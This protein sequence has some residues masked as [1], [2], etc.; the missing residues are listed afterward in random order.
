MISIRVLTAVWFALATTA[1]GGNILVVPG[2]YQTIYYAIL[3]AQDGDT[4]IVEPGIRAHPFDYGGK[5]ITISSIDPNDPAIVASTILKSD[6]TQPVVRFAGT[7]TAE[8][9][10]TGFTITGGAATGQAQDGWGGGISC[11]GASPT[12]ENCIVTGNMAL[13]GGGIADCHGSIRNC[14][15]S[16]NEIIPPLPGGGGGLYR[17]NGEIV[18]CL[19]S[20]NKVPYGSGGGLAGC[21]GRIENCLVVGNVAS[22]GGGFAGG[23]GL[24][25][26]CTIVGNYA[27]TGPAM[28]ACDGIITNSIVWYHGDGAPLPIVDSSQPTFSCIQYATSGLGVTGNDPRF[29]DPGSWANGQIGSSWVL[30][31]NRLRAGSPCIDTGDNLAVS[32]LTDIAGKNRLSRCFVDIGAYEFPWPVSPLPGNT[33]PASGGI[34]A[35]QPIDADDGQPTGWQ[36]VEMTLDQ[37]PAVVPVSDDFGIVEIGSDGL[38]P[39]IMAV[40]AVDALTFLVMLDEP[41]AIGA[42]TIITHI[43]SGARVQLGYLPADVFGNGVSTTA[44]VITLIELIECGDALPD[45][46]TDTN[47]SGSTNAE[48]IETL[49]DLLNGVDGANSY[50]NVSLPPLP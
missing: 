3:D 49:I 45:Y 21:N 18:N 23:D 28:L 48:D 14:I 1:F 34:D 5:L 46:S 25:S 19:I 20:N 13:S 31:D 7:E 35:R 11:H 8:A 6:G 4:I 36:S 30:G 15:I 44:D 29:I 26:N 17:C 50:S 24:I 16:G 2:Q 38:A 41:I 9:V 47:R 22:A 42:W 43:A 10:L 27:Y 39:I 33:A 37:A 40:S 12:I 32:A